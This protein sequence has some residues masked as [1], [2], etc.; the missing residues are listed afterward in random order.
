MTEKMEENNKAFVTTDRSKRKASQE[1][2]RSA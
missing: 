2:K 1:I